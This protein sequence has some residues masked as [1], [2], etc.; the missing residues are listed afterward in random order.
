MI[1]GFYSIWVDYKIWIDVHILI[2]YG[3]VR[4]CFLPILVNEMRH[5]YNV[6]TN[7]LDEGGND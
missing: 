1:L 5:Y 2:F 6:P 7:K 4:F 3:Y